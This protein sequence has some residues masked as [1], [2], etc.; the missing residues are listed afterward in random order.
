[1]TAAGG[2]AGR[3]LGVMVTLLP[4]GMASCGSAADKVFCGSSAD[5]D[6]SPEEW[7]KIA[8]LANLPAPLVDSSNSFVAVPAAQTLGQKF[9]F[10]ARFSGM[11]TQVD[12]LKRPVLAAFARAPKGTPVLV[13]CASCHDPN[14]AGIDDVSPG[15]V[16]IGAGEF[17]V[18]AQPTTNSAY[19][20]LLFWNGRSDSLWAQA[21]AAN[22]GA[23]S[24]N[25]TRLHDAWVI[26]DFYRTDYGATFPTYPLPLTGKSTDLLALLEADGARAG[27]CKLN[28]TNACPTDQGC[29]EVKDAT[30]AVTG[31]WPRF[32]LNGKPG[33]KAGCQPGDATEPF[34]D[35]WDCMAKD[36][37]DQ[38]NRVFVNFGKA[39][40]AYETEL[41]SN[42]SAFDQFISGGPDNAVI[43]SSAQRGARLFVG[44][45]A[46]SECHN[47]PLFSDNQFHNVGAPQTGHGVPTEAD[48]PSGGV[49]DCV[50]TPASTAPDGSMVAAKPAKN[51]LPWGARD[52]LSKLRA[53]TF[54]RGSTWSDNPSDGSRQPFL[55]DDTYPLDSVPKGAWR[56]PTLRDIAL[57][58][59][60]MHDGVY[61]SLADVIAHYNSGGDTNGEGVPAPQLRPL[62]LSDDEQ[63]DLVEFLKTLT[64]APLPVELRTAPVLP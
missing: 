48:C 51:C 12:N 18:N 4:L 10:D 54:L 16:S 56:T 25:S 44:K 23:V 50:G 6:W 21:V 62:F 20:T 31:C 19:Y 5:C 30:S 34:G 29:R 17:D 3:L 53:N 52:G 13:S 64:G 26:N 38:V 7:T 24:M 1:M 14:R 40:A 61:K 57:T 41:V 58:G 35:A 33:S 46:C 63:A 49:C 36:D 55:S 37:Q 22:E 42:D 39:I 8:A 47:T 45:A 27:Q 15:G 9:F 60:Y 59:P 28:A 32:P 11:A 2:R 43:S